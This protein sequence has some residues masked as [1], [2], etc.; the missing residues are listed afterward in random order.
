MRIKT[1]HCVPINDGFIA[2]YTAIRTNGVLRTVTTIYAVRMA[3]FTFAAVVIFTSGTARSA[4]VT[5]SYVFTNFTVFGS[6]SRA[7]GLAFFVTRKA[8]T[9]I[10]FVQSV[11]E[12]PSD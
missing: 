5:V 6:R 10:S 9:R 11:Q 12:M 2:R 8:M 3:R 4:R 7:H 1:H